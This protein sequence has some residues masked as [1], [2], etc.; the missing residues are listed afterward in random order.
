MHAFD[1]TL[2]AKLGFGDPDKGSSAHD[3][4]THYL[5]LPEN[6]QKVLSYL[7]GRDPTLRWELKGTSVEAPI[8]KGD[9]QYKTT[10]GFIDGCAKFDL[11]R[12]RTEE[13]INA[14]KAGIVE[15]RRLLEEKKRKDEETDRQHEEWCKQQG[16]PPYASTREYEE[17]PD[18]VEE[19][20]NL[21]DWMLFIEVKIHRVPMGDVIRQVKL[22]N[23][24]LNMLH[25]SDRS[26]WV[27][28]TQYDLSEAELSM[29]SGQHIHHFKLGESFK[30]WFDSREGGQKKVANL[31][32]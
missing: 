30:Q 7:F 18:L 15:K 24:Y 26:V 4:A 22:Y 32:I 23:E 31:E 11:F 1:R 3:L 25:S 16:I 8:S 9:G 5:L 20:E 14:Q 13:H 12:R 19:W 10:I 27:V 29:L 17:V 28:V 6:I 2:L 21:W